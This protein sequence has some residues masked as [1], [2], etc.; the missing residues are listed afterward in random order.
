MIQPLENMIK[1]LLLIE[2]A[3]FELLCM[4]THIKSYL[5]LLNGS[6]LNSRP[7][8]T[9]FF[10]ISLRFA[11]VHRKMYVEQRCLLALVM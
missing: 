7:M 1:F 5:R 8:S 9:V 4:F 11:T 3:L 2:V 10:N 6:N